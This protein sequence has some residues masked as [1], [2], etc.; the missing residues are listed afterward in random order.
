VPCHV[1]RRIE[2]ACEA[3][4]AYA[5]RTEAAGPDMHGAPAAHRAT[6]IAMHAADEL[7]R[8]AHVR[9]VR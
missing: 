9:G 8:E 1:V 6:S 5:R 3:P 7:A 2:G 4:A